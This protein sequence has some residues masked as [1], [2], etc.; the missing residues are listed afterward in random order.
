MTR[1]DNWLVG[2]LPMGMLD[3]GFFLRFVSMF[4]EVATTL[5]D[6]VDNIPH[7]VDPT[8]APPEMVRW[9]ASWI[10]LAPIDSSIDEGLQRRLVRTASA[11]LAW[12]G[13][14]GG[15]QRYLE[16]TTGAPAEV[17]ESG[18]V[19]RDEGA[20]APEPSVT[21]RVQNTGRMSAREFME[22]VRDELPANASYEIWVGDER[23][24]PAPG[25]EGDEAA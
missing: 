6:D 11:G 15:L 9:L 10:G 1:R 3:D 25:A 13:T 12:R 4:E 21:M 22:V 7:L 17:T 14:R 2:Q 16:A 23:V 24:W 19:R 8:V 18:S 5:L 20:P